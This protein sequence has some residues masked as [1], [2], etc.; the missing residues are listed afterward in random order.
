[1]SKKLVK[2]NKTK[3]KKCKWMT[4]GILK[5][6]NTRDKLYTILVQTDLGNR[7]LYN[8]LKNEYKAF[9]ATRSIKE[10]QNVYII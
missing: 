1:M 8:R 10:K 7:D 3:H 5:S 6:I 9:R 2:Y 4:D